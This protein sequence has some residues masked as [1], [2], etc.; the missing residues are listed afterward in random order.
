AYLKNLAGDDR[1]IRFLGDVSEETLRDLY[2][3]S[4]AVLYTP[5]RE[6]YGLITV[7]AMKSGKP[8]ITTA[9]AGGPLEFVRTGV[10]GW[11]ADPNPESLAEAIRDAVRTGDHLESMG[12][13]AMETVKHISW[14]N[15][16]EEILKSYR[17]WPLR[18]PRTPGE[19]RRLTMLVPY[20]V[21]P[22]RSGGQRR[23]AG[24]S[25]E[26]SRVYDVHILSLGRF[27]TPGETIEINPQLHEIRIPMAPGHARAQWKYE[28]AV[29]ET[30]SDVALPKLL[31]LTPNYIRA[32]EHYAECSDIILCEQPYMFPYIP[33]S[34]RVRLVVF[35]SQNFEYRLKK[36]ILS[37]TTPGRRLLMDTHSAEAAAVSRSDVFFATSPV[38]GDE[39]IRFYRRPDGDF[40][41]AA[42]GVDTDAVQPFSNRERSDAREIMG[43]SEDRYVYLFVGAWHPPNL[44]AVCFIAEHLAPVFT[45]DLFLIVGSVRDHYR[46]QIGDPERLPDNMV[47]TGEID[48]AEKDRA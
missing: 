23:V 34:H 7:E 26:L 3:R 42:N 31:R 6:D 39:L 15:T 24:L 12:L 9:D 44:E 14:R 27:N 36:P 4:V 43:I 46:Q 17:Y 22:P 13:R 18:E 28:E 37:D 8:V 10:N 11:V 48:E 33:P 1:R 45:D 20:P 40:T 5:Y 35:S 38:E 41:V 30:V 29:G 2:A 19:P 47:L 21:F 16:V 25:I 32:L